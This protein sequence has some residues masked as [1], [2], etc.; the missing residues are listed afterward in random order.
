MILS[1][2][3]NSV[4]L[5]PVVKNLSE[6]GKI[7]LQTN[8]II[9]L[10]VSAPTCAFCKNLEK[11]VISPLIRSG[12]YLDEIILRKI[13]RT[14]SIPIKDFSGNEMIPS[15]FLKR[16]D[17]QITPTLLF[18]DAKGSQVIEPLLGYRGGEFFWYYFDIA[19]NKANKRLENSSSSNKLQLPN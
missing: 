17:I 14:S 16:Y 3:C 9:L 5:I 18:L 12:K 2:Y 10:Y 19:I 4:E 15:V 1:G 13:D 7:Q 11:K 8:R 6:D